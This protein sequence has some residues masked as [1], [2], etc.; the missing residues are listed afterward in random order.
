ML[1]LIIGY[2]AAFAVVGALSGLAVPYGGPWS[3]IL[4]NV[5]LGFLVGLFLSVTW[6]A[7]IV[8]ALTG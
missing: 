7:G 8:I 4:Q 2:F 6:P 3:S 1:L 5:W